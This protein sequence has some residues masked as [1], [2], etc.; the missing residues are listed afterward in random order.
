MLEPLG[1]A[2][3]VTPQGVQPDAPMKRVNEVL[4]QT[5]QRFKQ[6]L[7]TVALGPRDDE[8][9]KR[10]VTIDGPDGIGLKMIIHEPKD[11]AFI[12]HP[13]L[14]HIHGGGVGLMTAESAFFERLREHLA[15]AGFVV[16]GVDYRTA[17]GEQGGAPFPAGL[18]DC[19]AAIEWVATHKDELGA[20][21]IVLLGEAGGAGLALALALK[22]KEESLLRFVD[23]V[24]ACCPFISNAF[25]AK[26]APD[27]CIG[28]H[29]LSSLVENDGYIITTELLSLLARAYSP[30]K[31][32][33]GHPLAWVLH[34]EE[35]ELR[36]LPP[37]VISVNEMDPLRDEGLAYYR[38]LNAA[39]VRGYSRI[40]SGTPHG[41][42]LYFAKAIPDVFDA[43]LRDIKGFAESL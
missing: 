2:E 17:G 31:S 7:A 20:G 25:D 23:G 15:A 9:A 30:D 18:S 12:V 26:G 1:L 38:R 13:C 41:A 37:H 39:G 27:A 42:D 43:T 22:L 3:N 36:G 6:I 10:V 5:E 40:V 19:A 24:Y 14:V 4:K 33:D 21:K 11:R 8:V 16:V 32:A 29:S 35:H 28:E 34:A